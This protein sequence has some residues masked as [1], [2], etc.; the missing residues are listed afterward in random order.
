MTIIEG[1]II[2]QETHHWSETNIESS[3]SFSY[4]GK[5]GG[6]IQHPQISS[7]TTK[8]MQTELWVKEDDGI[9]HHIRLTN[10]NF[11]TAKNHRV[12]IA[13]GG[14]I[15]NRQYGTYLFAYNFNS[16][17][18][19]DFNWGSWTKW[20]KARNLIIY[21]QNYILIVR[22]APII[23]GTIISITDNILIRTISTHAP[24]VAFTLTLMA[25]LSL[26]FWAAFETIG[27]FF[28]ATPLINKIAITTRESILREFSR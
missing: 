24:S 6:Y 22:S 16:G 20:V 4:I 11:A 28:F 7:T 26:A 17:I 18:T 5:G 10:H 8:H 1:V 2:H 13:W 12:R 21:P 23:A 9:E 27:Q 3:E 14:S 19:V 25:I 15:S